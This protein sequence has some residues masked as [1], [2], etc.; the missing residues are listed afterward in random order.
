MCLFIILFILL[1]SHPHPSDYPLF[2]NMKIWRKIQLTENQYKSDE[3]ILSVV[4]DFGQQ[5][6]SFFTDSIQ[7]RK[8]CADH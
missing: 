6:E 2:P 5:D 8:K 4:D 1:I 3:E 7:A